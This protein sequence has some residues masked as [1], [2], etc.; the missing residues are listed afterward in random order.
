[1]FQIEPSWFQIDTWFVVL[2]IIGVI[3]FIAIAVIWGVRA[4]RRQTSAGREDLIGKTAEVKTAL[5]PK[6]TVLIQGEQW[7]AISE[8]GRVES[9][10]EVIITKVDN[11]KLW[12]TKKTKGGK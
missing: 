8:R 3:A 5:G 4:H 6:G 10:E 2:V 7:T 9:G 12:V 11:L 1:M